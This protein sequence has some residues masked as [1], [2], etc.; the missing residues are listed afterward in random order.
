MSSRSD[1]AVIG[2]AGTQIDRTCYLAAIRPVCCR[3]LTYVLRSDARH[4]IPRHGAFD[5]VH[6]IIIF[7]S[8]DVPNSQKVA[9]LNQC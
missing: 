8:Y 7:A 5:P 3:A 4:I 6:R 9:P 2:W 1:A